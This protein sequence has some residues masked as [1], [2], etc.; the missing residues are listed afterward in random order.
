MLSL[1]ASVNIPLLDN[2][3]EHLIDPIILL[4]FGLALIIFLYG[5]VQFLWQG[6]TLKNSTQGRDK[7]IWG[8]VGIVIMLSVYGILHVLSNTINQLMGG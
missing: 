1:L 8:L 2:I 5:L 4:L 7:I 3:K 6:D